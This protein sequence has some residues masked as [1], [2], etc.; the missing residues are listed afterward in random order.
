[1]KKEAEMMQ[2][3]ENWIKEVS[4]T[5]E[6]R[7]FKKIENIVNNSEWEYWENKYISINMSSIICI[8]N[9]VFEENNQSDLK[10]VFPNIYCEIHE[11]VWQNLNEKFAKYG[12]KIG[13]FRHNK[14]EFAIA[15]S[16]YEDIIGIGEQK[17]LIQKIKEVFIK[18]NG[19]KSS[20]KLLIEEFPIEEVKE[21]EEKEKK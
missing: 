9:D 5:I 17:E 11:T 16:D 19:K 20:N 3:K 15:A 10:E 12:F 8:F 7:V 13:K 21:T 18:L 4:K 1:M 2:E 6:D 14:K